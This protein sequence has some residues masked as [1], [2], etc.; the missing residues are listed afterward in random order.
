MN[1]AQ[2]QVETLTERPKPKAWRQMWQLL[3]FRP[4][5]YLTVGFLQTLVYG[6]FPQATG[7]IMQAFFNTLTG[8]AQVQVG[9]WSLIALLVATAIARGAVA[10]ASIGTFFAFRHTIAALL[11]RSLFDHILSRPSA[12]AVPYSPGEVVSRF[13]GD[14]DEIADF[15]TEL[16]DVIGFAL[17]AVVAIVIMLRVNVSITLLVFLPLVIVVVATNRAMRGLQE[18]RQARREAIGSVTDFIGEMFG[19]AQAIKVA[20]AE[21]RMIERFHALNETRRKAALRDRLFSELLRSVVWNAINLGTGL[22]LLLTGQSMRTGAFTVGDLALFVYYL[23]FVAEFTEI[24]GTTWA[25]YKQ[26]EVSLERLVELLQ[27]APPE[28]LVKHG[29][30]YM[31]GALPDVP[32]VP[33]T[34]AHRLEKLEA[35]GLTYKYPGSE[36]GI[37]N[38]NFCLER[39][40]F[41]V[42]TG[43]VGSGKTTFLRTLLGLLPKSAGE[44]RWNGKL[45]NDPV[46]FFVP[47]RS[48]YTPQVS[49]LFS[50]SLADNILMGLPEE[51]VNFQAAIWL[52]VMEQDLKDLEH[53]LDTVVGAKGIKLSGGQI[54]RTAAARTF[55]R[56][57]ELLVFDDLSSALDVETEQVLWERVF[58][59]QDTTCLVVSHR[60]PALR[61]ADHIIVLK[62]GRV[63]A[64]GTLETLLESCEEMQR[65]WNT[66]QTKLEKPLTNHTTL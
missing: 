21:S 16:S 26:M 10:F 7:L 23:G 39:G 17:F 6:V 48:A 28:T 57:P 1:A 29:P 14:V 19:V 47:P 34:D 11:R 36:K 52:A 44:I 53:G 18:Y 40:S 2:P 25:W 8:Q 62:D 20:T 65:L 54:Q 46:S 50:E 60:R 51:K 66:V 56:D 3:R 42:I 24:I 15:L 49:L 59:C 37:E 31:R 27:G 35:V 38:I 13:R 30:V 22:I 32:Y 33:K 64:E 63:A 5:L 9:P 4:G 55:V 41:T 61:H 45:I 43:H 12:R 58:E